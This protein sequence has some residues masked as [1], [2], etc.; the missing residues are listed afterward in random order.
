MDPQCSFSEFR[1]AFSGSERRD[2]LDASATAHLEWQ[3]DG[4]FCKFHVQADQTVN[5]RVLV[6]LIVTF[7]LL[8]GAARTQDV[9]SSPQHAA[10]KALVA[11]L[12]DDRF[13]LRE[14]AT[15]R[16]IA[17]GV[18]AREALQSGIASGDQEV[19]FRSRAVLAIIRDLDLHQ[20]L[21]DF[22]EDSNVS[23]DYGLPGWRRFRELT[24]GNP[25]AKPLFVGMYRAEA[26]LMESADQT[27][28]EIGLAVD[29]RCFE[30]QQ[31]VQFL[32]IRHSTNS[33][34]ALLFLL[35]IED[36]PLHPP[37]NSALNFFCRQGD[38]AKAT[39]SGPSRFAFHQML[40]KWLSREE[41]EPPRQALI[42]GMQLDIHE[43]LPR[44]RRILRDPAGMAFDRQYAI[45]AIA[46]FGDQAD[47][48]VLEELLDDRVV[49]TQVHR[50][51]IRVSVQVRDVALAALLH[52]D[53]PN[54]S[55]S[56]YPSL[57][58]RPPFVFKLSSLGF[59]TD[60]QRQRA[61]REWAAGKQPD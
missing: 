26:K 53:K 34:A 30:L 44:A 54:F 32:G 41:N 21:D 9:E 61:L 37:T 8:V 20:R 19:R 45:L 51:D 17:I 36:V 1:I 25:G 7:T 28:H 57:L 40:G 22:A 5:Y 4:M 11:Q 31:S 35:E 18:R 49:C 16:L 27:P 58:R 50:R 14:R 10:A 24:G 29:R 48:P 56:A 60:E 6:F 3:M 23:H 12:G 59:E 13:A 42:L 38:V 52:L 43:I 15:S 46:K 39:R 33:V 47:I 2:S 55:E